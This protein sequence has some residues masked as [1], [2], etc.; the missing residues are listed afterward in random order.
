VAFLAEAEGFEHLHVH[1]V[2]SWHKARRGPRVTAGS[3]Q[4]LR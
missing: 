4:D 1:V 2:P 3:G